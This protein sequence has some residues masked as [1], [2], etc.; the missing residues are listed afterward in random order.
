MMECYPPCRLPTYEL[1]VMPTMTKDPE[2]KSTPPTLTLN[3]RAAKPYMTYRS[4]FL[5]YDLG[6]LAGEVGGMIGILLGA[7][8]L[9]MYDIMGEWCGRLKKKLNI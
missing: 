8:M 7:S 1:A 4:E 9:T 5:V 6:S 3:L 2:P